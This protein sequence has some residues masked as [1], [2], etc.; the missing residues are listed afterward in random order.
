MYNDFDQHFLSP[1]VRLTPVKVCDFTGLRKHG[2]C[3]KLSAPSRPPDRCETFLLG[4]QTVV[5]QA[6]QG[7]HLKKLPALVGMLLRVEFLRPDGTPRYKRPMWLFWTGP[8]SVALK[9]LCQMYLWRFAIEHLFRFL[10]QHMGLNANQ[11]TDPVSTDQWMWLCA[12]A[13]WQLLL[14]RDE[15]ENGRPAWFPARSAA[16]E[17]KMTPRQV[18]RGALRYLVQLGTPALPTR[19]AGKGKGRSIGFHPVHR[20]RFAVVKKAKIASD[21]TATDI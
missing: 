18:Q 1:T 8:E 20:Q 9:E 21:R 2:T 13:Y 19:T 4:Q 3:F 5:L 11:S 7:L 17:S 15:V 12:L 6:W 10:K 16:G 14:M